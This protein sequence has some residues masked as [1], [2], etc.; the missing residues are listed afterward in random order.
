MKKGRKEDARNYRLLSLTSITG[1]VMEQ[2]ILKMISRHCKD[3]KSSGAVNVA[4]PRRSSCF[5][6]MINFY[7]GAP[8]LAD[9]KERSDLST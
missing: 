5:T 2:I 1:K 6:S 4:S 7:S 8:G 3:S 9:K